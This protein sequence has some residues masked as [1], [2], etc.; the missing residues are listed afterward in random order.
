MALNTAERVSREASDNYVFQR[1]LLAYVEA[2]AL[3][4]GR[5]LEV[6]TGTGYGI[7]IIREAYE[8]TVTATN[9]PSVAYA[10]AILERWNAEGLKTLEEIREAQEKQKK[11]NAKAEETKLGNSFDT[12]DFFEAAL[13]RSFSA[14]RED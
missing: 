13:Q 5:V 9:E 12:D 1:S 10:N 7:D 4:S 14:R 8:L 6:G 3:V 2:S 11:G